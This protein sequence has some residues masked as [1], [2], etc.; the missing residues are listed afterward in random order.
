MAKVIF[1]IT[2][3]DPQDGSLLEPHEVAYNLDKECDHIGYTSVSIDYDVIE[4]D[5]SF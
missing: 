5:G 1:T 3:D 2:Y 4:S